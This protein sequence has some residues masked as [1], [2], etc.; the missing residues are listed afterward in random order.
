MTDYKCNICGEFTFFGSHKCPPA[1]RVM[2]DEG[3]K[4]PSV[5]YMQDAKPTYA[6]TSKDAAIK[7]AEKHFSD[8]EYPSTMDLWVMPDNFPYDAKSVPLEKFSIGVEPVPSFFE[9]S[10]E[11]TE[12]KFEEEEVEPE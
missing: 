8:L 1:W 9:Q 7:W 2:N 3:G 4:V 5:E 10:H 6:T 12:A 11:T